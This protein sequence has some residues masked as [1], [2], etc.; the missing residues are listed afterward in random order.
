MIGCSRVAGERADAPSTFA[1]GE[2]VGGHKRAG[3]RA[4][5]ACPSAEDGQPTGKI[6]PSMG[7]EER[8][9]NIVRPLISKP[10]DSFVLLGDTSCRSRG[11]QGIYSRFLPLHHHSGCVKPHGHECIRETYRAKPAPRR[12]AS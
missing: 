10:L 12:F 1:A 5:R 6:G 11:G 4:G 3:L 7:S 9:L 8:M 2:G